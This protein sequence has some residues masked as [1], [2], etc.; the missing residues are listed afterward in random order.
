[1]AVL[2]ALLSL[3]VAGYI[4]LQVPA[5]QTAIG[6]KV[7]G[8][9][10]RNINGEISVG[11]IYVVFFN[12]VI[13]NDISIVSRERTPLLDSLKTNFNQS[14]TLLACKKL[15]VT[16]K[17]VELLKF[18]L[19][20][21]TISLKDGVFNLQTEQEKYTNL[22]R[23]FKLDK[24]APKDTSK[25]GTPELLANTLRVEDFRFTL[26][27]PARFQRKGDSIINFSN[28]SVRDIFINI[29]DVHLKSDT[30]YASINNISG[31][32]RSGFALKGLNGKARVSS[33][34]TLV[35][36][37][38][39][40]DNYTA[41]NAKY[42]YMKYDSPRDLADFTTKVKLGI[43][44]EDS[45]LSFKTI[46]RIAPSLYRSSLAFY[47][48]GEVS[49]TV[50]NIRTSSLVAV[51]ES[52]QTFI[53][54]GARVMGLPDVSRTMAVAEVKRSYTTCRDIADIVSSIGN[55]PRNKFLAGLSPFVRYRFTGDLMGLLDD[56]VA[57]GSIES[58]VGRIDLDLLFRNET[59]TGVRFDGNI[60]SNDLHIG[61]ILSN[62][63]L[64][65]LTLDAGVNALFKKNGAG[66]DIKIDSVRVSRFGLNGYDYSNIYATGRYTDK[67]FNGS[68]ICHDPNLDFIFQG[69]FSFAKGGDQRSIFESGAG[70]RP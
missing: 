40:A 53:E 38:H 24:N 55:T 46:G 19:K 64:G 25:G 13:V 16:L 39:I 45:F 48:N 69:L 49:G 60:K 41:V 14:D 18:K 5:V 59:G 20:L 44:L 68:L 33:T 57:D 37:L 9:L 11:N 50:D 1:M 21:N 42:F 22:D 65:E 27:N 34:E 54:L 6:K 3:Q 15:S 70:S 67:N 26:N 66:M 43:S 12:R 47:L 17:P 29:S 8:A 7:V 51:S 28:L 56:F 61:R 23:I 2:V 32:D 62:D 30:I 63:L 4:I 31:R 35:S 52:G 58:S 10:S 36:D